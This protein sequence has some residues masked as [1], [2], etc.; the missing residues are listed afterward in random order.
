MSI[1]AGV[2]LI[3]SG[4]NSTIPAGW[5]RETALDG[6]FPK[7]HGAQNPNISGGSNTHTHTG[8][9]THTL[10]SHNHS[11]SLN[12]YSVG[13]NNGVD[14]GSSENGS[15]KHSHGSATSSSMSGGSLQSIG[16]W[17]SV[18]QEP[19]NHRVIFIKPSGVV[20]TIL[21]GIIAHFN[22][23]SSPLGWNFCDG[24]NSTPDLRDK[25]LKGASAGA[26]AGT[27]GGAI[28]HQHTV[29][30]QHTANS[31]SHTGT[32]PIMTGQ[33]SRLS[34]ANGASFPLKTHTHTIT[35]TGVDTSS[36]YIK[37]DAGASDS[38][39]PSY[40]KMGL[41]QCATP[42]LKV[43][44]VGLWLGSIASIP[45]NWQVCD[46]SNGTVDMRD[47]FIKIP[48][49]LSGNGVIGGSNTHTHTPV[50]HTHTGSHG[51]TGTSD[52]G[53]EG[54]FKADGYNTGELIPTSHT[55]TATINSNTT[56]YSTDDMTASSVDNQP[57]YLTVAYIQLMKIPSLGAGL[58]ALM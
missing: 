33:W 43:G 52:G 36:N 10:N 5:T 28:T 49:N 17:S 4:L 40:K 29:T 44:M 35:F 27:T 2:I 34:A 31:H 41:I 32:S 54:V 42:V 37:T 38:V 6:K 15:G 45:K 23:S 57:S 19:P 21:A 16:S 30:H 55:H 18:N 26:D 7:G 48:T 11:F 24:G 50:S 22:G 12:Q 53:S 25:Y 20:A 8:D 39:E 3:W 14:V 47:V 56:T 9:H 58:M 13:A 46:G 1:P 51:H